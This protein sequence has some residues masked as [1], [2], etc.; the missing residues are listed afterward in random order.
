ML[1]YQVLSIVK[2]ES[3]AISIT[4]VIDRLLSSA[5]RRIRKSQAK[6]N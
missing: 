3:G 2:K 6:I 5:G 1:P 4:R